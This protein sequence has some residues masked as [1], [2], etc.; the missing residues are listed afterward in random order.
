MTIRLSVGRLTEGTFLFNNFEIVDVGSAA[1][2]TRIDASL[3][4]FLP[5]IIQGDGTL[6]DQLTV[7]IDENYQTAVSFYNLTIS[8]EIDTALGGLNIIGSEVDDQIE[9]SSGND[10]IHGGLGDDLILADWQR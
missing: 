5:L 4:N 10:I 9:G 2:E 1:P 7:E 6:S 3:I 8:S